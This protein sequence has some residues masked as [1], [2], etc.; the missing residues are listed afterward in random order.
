MTDQLY[1]ER[2][3]IIVHQPEHLDGKIETI[4]LGPPHVTMEMFALAIADVV[5]HVANWA[6]VDALDVL[7][8]V[9]REIQDPTTELTTRK[10]S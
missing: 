3:Y 10:P 8:R 2:P 6:N 4:L 1:L 5:G 9:E 7:S